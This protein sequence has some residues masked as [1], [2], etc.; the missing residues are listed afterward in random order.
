MDIADVLKHALAITLVWSAVSVVASVFIGKWIAFGN[1]PT[2]DEL[3]V[4]A[5]PAAPRPR[6]RSLD[7]A[8]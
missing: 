4:V 6:R 5:E 3:A 8:A 2:C 7:S 1:A